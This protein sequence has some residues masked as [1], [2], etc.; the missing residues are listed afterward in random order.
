MLRKLLL[1]LFLAANISVVY[2]QIPS[3]YNG[4][5]F[6]KS[7][8]V[9]FIELSGRLQSTH[10][11]IPYTASSTDSWDVLRLSDE[12][13]DNP[14]NV[15]LLYGFND[16]DGNPETDRT[17]DKSETD[18]GG[19]DPGKWNREHIF[20]RS[21][22]NPNLSTDSPGPGTDLYNLR[23]ADSD[24]NTDRSNRKFT[25]GSGDSGVI[26]SNGGWYPGDEWKGDVA[27]AVM[28]MYLRYHGNGLQSSET[29]CLPTAVGFGEALAED[30]NMINL[31]LQWNVEDPVSD[32]EA[33]HNEVIVEHQGNRNP[34][35]DNPYLA[36]LIWG[37]LSAEDKWDLG[38]SDDSENPT[39]PLNLVVDEVTDT[40]ISFSWQASTDNV[41]VFDYLIYVDGEYWQ[42]ATTTSATISGLST[43][44]NYEISVKARDTSSNLSDESS[45]LEVTT[46][47]GPFLLF[48]EDFNDCASAQFLAYSE[49]SNKDWICESQFGENNSGSFGINGYQEEEYSKDWLI[50]VNAIDFDA[51]E[52]ELLSF[53]TD[54]AYGTTPLLLVYSSDY[55]GSGNPANFT[56]IN[57]PNVTIPNHSDGSGTEEVYKFTDVDISSISGTVYFAFKYY[58]DGVPTR[59]TVDNFE[60]AAAKPTEDSDGDG[61]LNYADLCPD[62]E[63]GEEVDSNGCSI[64][65]L[66]DDNDGIQNSD[67]QCADTPIGEDV[68]S[69]GCS[70]SQLDDD[71]D[72]VMNDVDT[73]PNTPNGEE[74]DTNGC[75]N[76]QLDDDNDG[77]TNDIDI[78]PDTEAGAVVDSTGCAIFSLPSSNFTIEAVSETCPDKNNGQILISANENY[79]YQT[80]IAGTSYSFTS[81][82]EVS[83]LAP[84]NYDFCIT[85]EGE[86]YEQCFELTVIE[87]TTISGKSSLKA[88]VL[89]IEITQGTAPFVIHRNNELLFESSSS[90]FDVIVNNGD[91]IEVYSAIDCEGAYSKQVQLFD[92][93]TAFPNPT[94]NGN[95]TLA[96]PNYFEETVK[97]NVF[98]IRSK[99]MLSRSI[100]IKNERG[101]LDLSSLP[102]GIYFIDFKNENL[103]GLKIIK[104]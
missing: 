97:I 41:E 85:V 39:V 92:G 3:Y 55:D 59:W 56:W 75:S 26:S 73:C 66:D 17:R 67:D 57:V 89:N 86:D 52:D 87:G 16:S 82:L 46:L 99:L 100:S 51:N 11:A 45:V 104:R 62:T 9:L 103:K 30:P 36:T 79:N 1:G 18:S 64:G 21:L 20:A 58:S 27:R 50:T 74:V 6:T 31:F 4:L 29:Q 8:N 32:F 22:A 35:I 15:L 95:I 76:G 10:I 53:Y 40:E 54:A 60:I 94:D 23:P 5:D 72:G 61:V 44:T 78:C 7:G 88:K 25:D 101:V 77:I 70:D 28:Y 43:S 42:T 47:E 2:S 81:Y 91:L 80:N 102:N 65:Q 96:I 48:S 90:T 19:G 84:E 98:D 14:N 63:A 71:E 37:G 38:N 83:D 69:N 34:F 93:I 13:P 24:R 68:N 49:A 33:N 12:D